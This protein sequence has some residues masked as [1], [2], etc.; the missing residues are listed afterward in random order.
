MVTFKPRLFKRRPSDAA[1][2]P[3][4]KD[5]TTPPVTKIYFGMTEKILLNVIYVSKI[6]YKTY[7]FSG[8]STPKIPKVLATVV[9]QLE[10]D[11][12]GRIAEADL[13]GEGE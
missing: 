3:F 7:I 4:P 8:A 13:G 6:I 5:E 1:V 11:L 10:V 9:V 12:V 2:I